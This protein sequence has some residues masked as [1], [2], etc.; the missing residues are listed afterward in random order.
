MEPTSLILRV[1]LRDSLAVF[2]TTF[3]LMYCEGFLPNQRIYA[4]LP[5]TYE[6]DPSSSYSWTYPIKAPIKLT[7]E[8][9]NNNKTI[10]LLAKIYN[11]TISDILPVSLMIYSCKSCGDNTI[12][13][14]KTSKC[15]RREITEESSIILLQAV[16]AGSN[17]VK[18]PEHN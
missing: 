7:K 10:R 17:N 16:T 18:R 13:D 3:Q 14:A 1:L 12:R 8:L 11:L 5:P 9:L 2:L 4:S 6:N 15:L